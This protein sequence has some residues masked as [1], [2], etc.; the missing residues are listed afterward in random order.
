MMDIALR[1]V[2]WVR[3]EMRGDRDDKVACQ[4]MRPTDSE[5]L[6]PGPNDERIGE[7]S[8]R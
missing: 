4:G 2:D 7:L 5:L 3:D 8:M 6:R 1:S